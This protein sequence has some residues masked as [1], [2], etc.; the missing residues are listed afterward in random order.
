VCSSKER[1]SWEV[2]QALSPVRNQRENRRRYP[3]KEIVARKTKSDM[4]GI[5]SGTERGTFWRKVPSGGRAEV[6]V[7]HAGRFPKSM[8]VD[9]FMEKNK[10]SSKFERKN[11][12]VADV[13]RRKRMCKKK[14]EIALSRGR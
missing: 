9:L 5:L 6:H 3:A 8:V 10:A 12:C 11:S 14:F 2:L 1:S 7:E 4:N 13:F